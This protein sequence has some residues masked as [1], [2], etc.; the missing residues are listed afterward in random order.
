MPTSLDEGAGV[1]A[2]RPRFLLK[3]VFTEELLEAF[4]S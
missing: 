3:G 1:S 4:I 2:G